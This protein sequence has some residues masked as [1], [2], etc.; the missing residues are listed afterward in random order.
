MLKRTLYFGNPA[1]LNTLNKQLIIQLPVKKENKS[2]PISDVA[3]VILDNSQITIT[4]P[5]INQLL[6]NNVALV[7]CDQTHHP[8]S[9]L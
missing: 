8:P 7:V 5:L 4:Q 9:L 3:V 2:I 1:Y 6:E